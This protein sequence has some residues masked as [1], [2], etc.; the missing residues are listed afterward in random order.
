MKLGTVGSR[1]Q[2]DLP[3]NDTK[4]DYFVLGKR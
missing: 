3:L 4:Y 1:L 2:D